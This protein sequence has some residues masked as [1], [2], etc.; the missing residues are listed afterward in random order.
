MNE[1]ARV[2]KAKIRYADANGNECKITDKVDQINFDFSNGAT[3]RVD[4]AAVPKPMRAIATVRGLAEKIRDTYAGSETVEDAFA[5]AEDMLG[6][7]M[8]GEWMSAREGGG[9]RMTMLL[10][11]IAEVKAAHGAPFDLEEARARYLNTAEDDDAT[12]E[13]KL[14]RRKAAAANSEVAAVLDRLRAEA[15]AKRADKTPVDAASVDAL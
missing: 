9:P 1:M 6:R 11:A 14:G 5:E 13:A 2:A 7:L 10:T 12:R 3:V 8:D 4:L 15:A